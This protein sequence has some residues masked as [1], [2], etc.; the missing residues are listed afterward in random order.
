[1][2]FRYALRLDFKWIAKEIGIGIENRRNRAGAADAANAMPI[3]HRQL[4]NAF[5]SHPLSSPAAAL[6]ALDS[7]ERTINPVPGSRSHSFSLSLTL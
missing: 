7:G 2:L 3:V 4:A 6:F 5:A 1:M